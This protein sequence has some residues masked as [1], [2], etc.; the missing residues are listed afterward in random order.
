M[1]LSLSVHQRT[2]VLAGAILFLLGLL[3]GG[4]VQNFANPRM[5]LSAHLTAVQCGMALMIA[6]VLWSAISLS[7]QY[8]TVSRW[9]MIIGFYGLWLALLASAATGASANLPIAGAGHEGSAAAEALVS[10]VVLGSSFLIVLS[11]F[12]FVVGL[13]R[14]K[15]S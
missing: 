6:G 7:A 9:A 5:A 3:Q 14:S 1:S 10:T 8:A 4:L 2:L 11:W 13:F 12:L 15:L